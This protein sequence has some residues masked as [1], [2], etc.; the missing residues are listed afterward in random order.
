[1]LIGQDQPAP[2]QPA[3]VIDQAVI[4]CREHIDIY[5][6]QFQVL[7]LYNT[8]VCLI[9]VGAF[10]YRDLIPSCPFILLAFFISQMVGRPYLCKVI[11]PL[12]TQLDFNIA[13]CAIVIK[14]DMQRL[15]SID[16]WIGNIV[17]IIRA[18]GFLQI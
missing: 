13:A 9:K 8:F 18:Y 15:I 1:M 17:F 2:V 10:P 4:R 16:A 12:C 14:R 7:Q 11:H 6:G 5:P 3:A